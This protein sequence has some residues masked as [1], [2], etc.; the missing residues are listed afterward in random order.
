MLN[1]FITFFLLNEESA[2]LIDAGRSSLNFPFSRSGC[3]VF[4][5][6]APEDSVAYE[7]TGILTHFHDLGLVVDSIHYGGWCG[8]SK[9]LSYQDIVVGTKV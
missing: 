9:Y 2:G 6:R 1:Y 8:R 3:W 5:D 4:D 7:E